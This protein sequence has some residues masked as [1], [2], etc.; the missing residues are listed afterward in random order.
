MAFPQ[1]IATN[2]TAISSASTTHNIDMPSSVPEGALLIV[3]IAYSALATPSTPSGWTE[4]EE[5]G[6]AALYAK[7]ADGT[8]GGTIVDFGTGSSC[9]CAAIAHC[10]TGWGGTLSTDVDTSNKRSRSKT[11]TLLYFHC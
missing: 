4:L 7:K 9:T 10:I 8:E 2:T 6:V 11:N 1:V 3:C 5:S